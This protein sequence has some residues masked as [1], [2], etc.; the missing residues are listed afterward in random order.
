VKESSSKGQPPMSCQRRAASPRGK[1]WD[2]I[3]GGNIQEG[4]TSFPADKTSRSSGL[5]PNQY[6]HK[7][8]PTQNPR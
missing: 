4:S 7:A 5:E 2:T 3:S 1:D 8:I 6:C